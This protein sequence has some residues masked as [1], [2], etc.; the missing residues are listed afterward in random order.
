MTFDK[1]VGTFYLKRQGIIQGIIVFN[2]FLYK[3]D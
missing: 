3:K 1:S 2:T